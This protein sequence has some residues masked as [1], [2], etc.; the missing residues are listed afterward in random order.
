MLSSGIR[1]FCGS[2]SENKRKQKIN[3]YCQRTKKQKQKLKNRQETEIP[4]VVGAHGTISNGL[5]M[6]LK[7]LEIRGR[8]ETILIIALLRSV[9]TLRRVMET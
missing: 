5:E 3:K 7:E 1:S 8:I 2:L 9:R 6:G 4:I